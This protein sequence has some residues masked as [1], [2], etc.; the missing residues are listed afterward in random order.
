MGPIPFWE[1]HKCDGCNG[2][3]PNTDL[4][5]LISIKDLLHLMYYTQKQKTNILNTNNM[6]RQRF[7]TSRVC[8]TDNYALSQRIH[9]NELTKN[10]SR[11]QEMLLKEEIVLKKTAYIKVFGRLIPLTSVEIPLY[12]GKTEIVWQ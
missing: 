9:C 8:S 11:L 6:P 3:D 2:L 12:E 4:Y 7:N 5:T 1:E 10:H